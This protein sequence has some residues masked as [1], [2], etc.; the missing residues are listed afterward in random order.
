MVVR[1]TILLDRIILMASYCSKYGSKSMVSFKFVSAKVGTHHLFSDI[2]LWSLVQYLTGLGK[3]S[4]DVR[5]RMAIRRNVTVWSGNVFSSSRL[6]GFPSH[7]VTGSF[8]K[9]DRYLAESLSFKPK[10]KSRLA[11]R[12]SHG[13]RYARLRQSRAQT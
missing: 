8:F 7:A 10:T 2:R 5:E 13:C 12:N 4:R 3:N 11:Q 6:T 1:W 9:F